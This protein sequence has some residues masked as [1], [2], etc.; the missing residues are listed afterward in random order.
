MLGGPFICVHD[1]ALTDT[2]FFRYSYS[3]GSTYESGATNTRRGWGS[4]AYMFSHAPKTASFPLTVQIR[5]LNARTEVIN[6]TTDFAEPQSRKSYYS[7]Y[8]TAY[9][10]ECAT[11][12][13]ATS[14]AQ[15]VDIT[16]CTGTHTENGVT[17]PSVQVT[18]LRS[19]G[20]VTYHSRGSTTIRYPGT[21]DY[22]YTYNY[23]RT[24]A[25][26]GTNRVAL[27]AGTD[28]TLQ[29]VVSVGTE[30]FNAELAEPVKAFGSSRS[31]PFGFQIS[32]AS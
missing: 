14:S 32:Y 27:V 17:S 16:V 21:P 29:S 6:L 28:Y 18:Q 23:D 8:G 3:D 26:Y 31:D 15:I 11:S 4:S 19:A 12:R 22:T 9:Q 10:Y 20:E 7:G 2:S 13:G 5:Q 24:I 25:T 30:T 1:Y